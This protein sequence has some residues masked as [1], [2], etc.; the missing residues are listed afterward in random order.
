MLDSYNMSFY[1]PGAPWAELPVDSRWDAKLAMKRDQPECIFSIIPERLGVERCPTLDKLVDLIQ[2][3]IKKDG[4]ESVTFSRQEET[5]HDLPGVLLKC[6]GF[7]NGRASHESRWIATRNG[8]LYQLRIAGPQSAAAEIDAVLQQMCPRFHQIEPELVVH[9]EGYD[10]AREFESKNFGYRIEL[11]DT[12]WWS[13]AKQAFESQGIEFE[14]ENGE[15]AVLAIFPVQ[16]AARETDLEVLASAMLRQV[17][18]TYP[19]ASVISS[20]KIESGKRPGLAIEAWSDNGK[21]ANG[22]C[23][24]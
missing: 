11:P 24:G 10:G 14:V 4:G 3:R 23:S 7:L 5:Y 18:I 19:G 17:N 9:S 15:H 6:D 21:V 2:E 20:G 22:R 13:V 12:G 8:F 1:L 16:L